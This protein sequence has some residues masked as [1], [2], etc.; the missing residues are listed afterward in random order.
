VATGRSRKQN[1]DASY[2]NMKPYQVNNEGDITLKILLKKVFIALSLTI[3]SLAVVNG[4][5]LIYLLK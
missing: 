1:V 3:L 2:I 4:F 5:Y